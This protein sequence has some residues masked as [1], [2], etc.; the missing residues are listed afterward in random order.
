MLMPRAGDRIQ[1]SADI[2]LTQ[3]GAHV[4][5]LHFHAALSNHYFGNEFLPVK[6]KQKAENP[7]FQFLE[8]KNMVRRLHSSLWIF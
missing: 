3:H 4:P 7:G 2:Y 1:G 5:L 6:T 8:K